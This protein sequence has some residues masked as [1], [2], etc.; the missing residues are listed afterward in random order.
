[1]VGEAPEVQFARPAK[2]FKDNE[3]LLTKTFSPEEMNTIFA[4]PIR[5]GAF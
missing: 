5:F 2:E 4:K 1:M 3:A